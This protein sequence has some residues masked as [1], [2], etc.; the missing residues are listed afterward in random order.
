V[1]DENDVEYE[2]HDEQR[3]S[4]F[5]GIIID[6]SDEHENASDSIRINLESDSNVIDESDLHHEKHDEP[7]IST[8]RE[9]VIFDELEK[10][11][12]NLCDTISI[13][14]AFIISKIVF[15]DSIEIESIVTSANAD[16]SINS[17]FRGITSD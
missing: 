1:I 3:I 6:R 14:N 16:P 13:K 2:K 4:T 9:I 5:R 7:K 17:R 10:L 15:P 12:I 11:R 8:E